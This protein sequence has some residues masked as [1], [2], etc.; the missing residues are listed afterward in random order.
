MTKEEQLANLARTLRVLND[1]LPQA[2]GLNVRNVTAY[3]IALDGL[4]LQHIAAGVQRL[5]REWDK[6]YVMPPPAVVRRAALEAVAEHLGLPSAEAAWAEV[7]YKIG[8]YGVRGIPQDGGGY[9][10]IE[11]SHPIVGDAVEAI[12]GTRYLSESDNQPTDRAHWLHKIYPAL[13]QSWHTRI[14]KELA[15]G[16]TPG[17]LQTGGQDGTEGQA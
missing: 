4:T 13:V 8:L 3:A 12:G 14:V 10:A 17:L 15:S 9:R 2:P 7:R 5:L 16:N 1:G 6:A 11:W